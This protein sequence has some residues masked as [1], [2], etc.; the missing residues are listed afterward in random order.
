MTNPSEEITHRKGGTTGFSSVYD[1]RSID[2]YV[3]LKDFNLE[4]TARQLGFDFSKKMTREEVDNF[5][6]FLTHALLEHG[7]IA[8]LD[9]RDVDKKNAE[10]ALLLQHKGP[11]L[12]P[13][14]KQEPPLSSE[15]Q[16]PLSPKKENTTHRVVKIGEV[17]VDSGQLLLVDPCYIGAL[18][19]NTEFK[20]I[21]IHK[22]TKTGD[23][24]E[25]KKDFEHYEQVIERYGKT[26][27]QLLADRETWE[28]VPVEFPRDELSYNTI[29][30]TTLSKNF[31]TEM[32]GQ[33]ANLAVATPT[34]LGDGRYDVNA[35]L[36]EDGR[37]TRI[38]IDFI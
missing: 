18:W 23:T 15:T 37:V 8:P 21:R 9:K 2:W 29:T 10:A 26:A 27:N 36:N 14:P 30:H 31:G 6:Y 24:I 20:D 17:S 12:L 38:F 34:G 33:V 3:N 25:Y 5:N 32:S 35:V 1:V 16:P 7:Y 19:K 11:G 22:N 13:R 28:D 4:S